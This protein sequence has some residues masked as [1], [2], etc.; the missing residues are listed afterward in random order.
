MILSF[1]GKSDDKKFG[2]LFVDSSPTIAEKVEKLFQQ[3]E[4]L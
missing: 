3:Q 2:S 1:E 4:N